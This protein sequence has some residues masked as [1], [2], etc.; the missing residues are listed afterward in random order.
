MACANVNVA[1]LVDLQVCVDGNRVTYE[2]SIAATVVSSGELGIGGYGEADGAFA[3]FSFITTLVFPA[4]GR[5]RIRV[6]L[7]DRN[8]GSGI[9]EKAGDTIFEYAYWLA[10]E[11]PNYLDCALVDVGDLSNH[12]WQGSSWQYIGRL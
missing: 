8:D 2:A 9:Y 6:L 10:P 12:C 4:G 3:Q 1:E 5:I 11:A 7:A